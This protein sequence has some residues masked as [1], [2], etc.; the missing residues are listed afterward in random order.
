VIELWVRSIRADRVGDHPALGGAESG[1]RVQLVIQQ[2]FA[3]GWLSWPELKRDDPPQEAS[4][5]LV[6]RNH[7]L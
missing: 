1:R 5:G 7:G 3:S 6:E 2:L 4:A